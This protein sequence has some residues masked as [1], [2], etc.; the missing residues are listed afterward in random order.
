MFIVF[1]VLDFIFFSIIELVYLKG[2]S[3]KGLELIFLLWVV[4][5]ILIKVFLYF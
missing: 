3:V 5:F 2:V 4:I 1:I